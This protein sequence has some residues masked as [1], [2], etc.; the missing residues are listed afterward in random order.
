MYETLTSTNWMS[1]VL[2]SVSASIIATIIY[3]LFKQPFKKKEYNIRCDEISTIIN[4]FPHYV[5]RQHY[6][7]VIFSDIQIINDGKY[8]ITSEELTCQDVNS[9]IKKEL[10]LFITIPDGGF[11]E[12][13][14]ITAN[15]EHEFNQTIIDGKTVGTTWSLLKA[16]SSFVLRMKIAFDDDKITEQNFFKSINVYSDAKN[17][18]ISKNICKQKSRVYN[19]I[20]PLFIFLFFPFF[21][22]VFH[23]IYYEKP[24]KTI[25]GQCTISRYGYINEYQGLLIY[26]LEYNIFRLYDS[27]DNSIRLY[28]FNSLIDEYSIDLELSK[29]ELLKQHQEYL[30]NKKLFQVCL[31]ICITVIMSFI[32]INLYR[33]KPL[34]SKLNIK[35][36][37]G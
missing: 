5:N 12:S 2:F 31:C 1:T 21:V 36:M 6:R 34:T 32:F 26:N 4:K 7:N 25:P 28:D 33:A 29:E 20:F 22:F 9:A 14:D 15:D 27:E 35:S 16:N 37:D 13:V 30:S 24:E 3:A 19:F 10:P 18:S 23:H 17:L 11:I 8:D